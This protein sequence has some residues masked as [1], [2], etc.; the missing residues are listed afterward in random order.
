M[1]CCVLSM[2]NN[3]NGPII[4]AP[5]RT[6]TTLENEIKEIEKDNKERKDSKE[7]KGEQQQPFEIKRVIDD[8]LVKETKA[9][10]YT[11]Y[12][13]IK[14]LGEG[15]FGSVEEVKHKI[16]GAIRAMK[17]IDKTRMRLGS[18]EEEQLINEIN[19]LKTL[20]HPN[21]MKVFEYYNY[22]NH[23]YIISEFI[24]GGELFD[25]ITENHNLKEDI[26]S[27]IMKQIFSAINF[28]HENDIVHRDLKPENILIEKEEKLDKDFL[29]IKIIDFGTCDKIKKGEK[30]EK[31]VGTPYYTAP[32]V[33]NKNYDKKCDL[34]S[35]GVILYVMLAGKQP[36]N[37]DNDEEINYAIQRCKIDFNDEIWDN[38]SHD[39]KDLIKNPKK[40]YS[41]K[42]A[43]NH[44]WIKNDKNKI[45]LDQ[46]K[47]KE[48]VDNLR[49]YSAKLKLQ[50]ATMAYIV[51]NLVNKKDY[52]YLR[53]IFIY[54][55]N[56]KDGKLDKKELINGLMILLD[57]TEAEKEVDRLFEII[58]VD[59]NGFIEYEEFLRAGL[60]K[61]KILTEYNLDTAFKLFDINNKEKMSEK[62]KNVWQILMEEAGI[63]I[64]E[65]IKKE[66]FK[67]IIEQC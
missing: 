67:R 38:I 56:D 21:I 64:N 53:Q 57:K 9:D 28:C 65:G 32:E 46:N 33:N 48:I 43:L 2:I 11:I 60:D 34:W 47:L 30:L 14:K 41:A 10:P 24:S 1:G 16:S 8:I 40:R 63:N 29:T 19:I 18:E 58:D 23:L 26:S 5:D 15:A 12:D 44:P 22:N 13:S 17:I 37:G 61:G 3:Q 54:L 35:C 39:A 36:F 27:N 31:Q 25:K 6:T 62:E 52:E 66:D 49:K 45:N 4:I 55:D 59:K 50:Q 7:K 51:H 20:D 42:D